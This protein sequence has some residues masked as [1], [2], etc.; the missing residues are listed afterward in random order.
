M[1]TKAL[2]LWRVLLTEKGYTW[3]QLRTFFTAHGNSRLQ[4]LVKYLEPFQPN[5]ED[6]NQ[7][8]IQPLALYKA[9]G[10]TDAVA[11]NKRDDRIYNALS[12]AYLLTRRFLWAQAAADDAFLP[13]YQVLLRCYT[14]HSL[15]AHFEDYWRELSKQ[16]AAQSLSVRSAA[17]ALFLAEAYAE[18]QS[19]LY[20]PT[21]IVVA[22]QGVERALHSDFSLLVL[23]YSISIKMIG[24]PEKTSFQ[25]PF[26][27]AV[28]LYL[29]HNRAEIKQN[30]PLLYTYFL[31]YKTLNSLNER[32]INRFLP[33]FIAHDALF[34]T[35][36]VRTLYGIIENILAI[37]IS[38]NI[39]HNAP[40]QTIYGLV[41]SV[42]QRQFELYNFLK[43]DQTIDILRFRN[44]VAVAL[45]CQKTADAH[46]FI[47]KMSDFLV[48]NTEKDDVVR[49]VRAL[50]QFE[51]GDFEAVIQNL[52]FKKFNE[53]AF[54]LL[55]EIVFIKAGFER[56]EA[57][58]S[59]K[60]R[61][62]EHG[63]RQSVHDFLALIPKC[64][65]ADSIQA[66]KYT[67][68]AQTLLALIDI[69]DNYKRNFAPDKLKKTFENDYLKQNNIVLEREW[70]LKKCI[71]L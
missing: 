58:H 18:F 71:G 23:R 10:Y 64:T 54:T 8:K 34:E 17:E 5:F 36:E 70:F 24:A 11:Q 35:A 60:G 4:G 9:L 28:L 14:H 63:T 13:P 42:Y 62:S 40:V 56:E 39:A 44:Y 67:A 37:L 47:S 51:E 27:P 43:P 61:H 52:R 68:F 16:Q 57:A 25:N 66:K 65:E 32:I 45:K 2:I 69:T 46:R 48:H 31:L 21:E 3:R 12:D 30:Q 33:V 49:Y 59:A 29:H 7:R 19:L 1:D 20:N 26:L 22:M 38:K 15:K 50:V 6:S 41:F 55:A 53:K